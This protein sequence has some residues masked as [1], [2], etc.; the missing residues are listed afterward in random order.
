[1]RPTRLPRAARHAAVIPR[2]IQFGRV[3]KSVNIPDLRKA[4]A[5][6][7][8][9]LGLTVGLAAAPAANP[10]SSGVVINEI[11]Y[12]PPDDREDLQFIEVFNAGTNAADLS[13]WRFTSGVDFDFPR[14]TRLEPGQFT[15]VC[16]E[17]AGFKSFYGPRLPVAGVFTGELGHGGRKLEL[18]DAHSNVVDVVKFTDRAPWP[19]AADGYGA[20][21]E[22]ICPS[23]PGDDPDNWAASALP[24]DGRGLGTPGARNSCFA[25]RPLPRIT[26]VSLSKAEAGKPVTVSASVT[27][28]AGC[29]SVDLL[30]AEWSGDGTLAW[31]EAAMERQAGDA[32]QGTYR[33]TVPGQPPERLIRVV[34]R[35]RSSTGAERMAPSKSDLRSAYSFSTFSN[36]NR[37]K[38]PC[39]VLLTPGPVRPGSPEGARPSRRSRLLDAVGAN[40]PAEPI[41]TWHSAA[42]I[43]PPGGG[44]PQVFDPVHVRPRRGGL[45]LHFAKDQAYSGMTAVDLLFKGPPRWILSE[46]LAQ[47]FYRIAGVLAPATEP[48]RLWVGQSLLGYFV[49]V[50]QPNRSFLRRNGRDPDGNLYK[51]IWYENGLIRRHEKQTNPRTGHQDLVQVVDGLNQ[52]DGAAQW[53]FIREHFAVDR[54]ID[55]YAVNMCIQDWDGFW[56]NY[57]A[58]HDLRPGGKWEVI[59]WDKDK[60]WGDFDGVSPEYDWYEMPLNYAM[61]GVRPVKNS[62]FEFGH[63]G[64][65]SWWRPPGFFSGPLL[66]N[67][68][69][70]RRF[71]A[72]LRELCET[73]FTPERMDPIIKG[74]A[75]KLEP[76][77]RALASARGHDEAAALMTFQRDVQSFHNQVA[78]RRA[79]LLKQL[80]AEQKRK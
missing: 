23:G 14:G 10:A 54:M 21:L 33:G 22:R 58:Y 34:V 4:L 57:Y 75:L 11:L 37:A 45:K 62:M 70:R 19:L 12:H 69:F 52:L 48:V 63:F 42:V 67:P 28:P 6:A 78:H 50:E 68:E 59:P 20:S 7:A 30:W 53:D 73:S 35:A 64:G 13:G 2:A 72:R 47:E 49:M 46:V 18:A 79:F 61:K 29:A 74:L 9:C 41:S 36:T 17:L 65:V 55:E 25:D 32:R 56:N 40:P 44:E 31:T 27:D 24:S 77:I 66:A 43:S 71:L 26:E 60:T 39:V 5:W 8:G 1:V 3:S 80:D 16:R 76:E 15:L 51:A 38:V